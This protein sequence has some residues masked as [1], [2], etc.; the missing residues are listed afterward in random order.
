MNNFIVPISGPSSS[1]SLPFSPE[2][3]TDRPWPAAAEYYAWRR[4]RLSYRMC[5]FVVLWPREGAWVLGVKLN[6]L[7]WSRFRGGDSIA[8]KKGLKKGPKKGPKVNLLQAY[9]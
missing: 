5:S 9:A 1:S 6:L 7:H 3:T 2:T 4:A 8:L